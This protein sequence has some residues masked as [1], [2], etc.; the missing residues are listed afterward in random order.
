M[1]AKLSD[2]AVE[3]ISISTP[4]SPK[5]KSLCGLGLRET[6]KWMCKGFEMLMGLEGNCQIEDGKSIH[7]MKFVKVVCESMS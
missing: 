1:E 6:L 3:G 7:F 4:A 5:S 2:N